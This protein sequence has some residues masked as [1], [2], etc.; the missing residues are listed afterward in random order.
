MN[1]YIYKVT[2]KFLTK[3]CIIFGKQLANSSIIISTTEKIDCKQ[4]MK[5]IMLHVYSREF[6]CLNF[7]S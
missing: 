3:K 1:K 2:Y 6:S 4:I 5:R 7:G